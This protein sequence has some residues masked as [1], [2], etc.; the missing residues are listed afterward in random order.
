MES[1]YGVSRGKSGEAATEKKD[2]RNKTHT[3]MAT[4]DSDD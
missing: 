4:T 2:Y 3:N 1:V